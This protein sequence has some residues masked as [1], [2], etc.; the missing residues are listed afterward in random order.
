MNTRK[1][2]LILLLLFVVTA[3]G[4]APAPQPDPVP[5]E[6]VTAGDL[7]LPAGFAARI[8]VEGLDGPTQMIK[9]PDGRLWVAQLAGD[10]N[11]GI[12][13]ILAIDLVSGERRVVTSD[14]MKPTGIAVLGGYLWIATKRD[15]LRVP[16][17]DQGNAGPTEVVLQSLPY[18]GRSNGT[19]T[20]SP[21]G[22]LI[23][24]TSGARFGGTPVAGSAT[25][26]QLSPANPAEPVPLA[27]GLKNAYAH[28]FDTRGGL[29]VTEIADDPVNG[30]TPPDEL[31]LVVE[32]ADFGWPKCYAEHEP[33]L[34][35]GGTAVYCL[36]VRAAAMTFAPRSTPTS[37][38]SSPWEPDTLLVALWLQG[39]VARV[40][41]A[42]VGDNGTGVQETFIEGLRN[43]Q[44]ILVWN[45]DTILVSDHSAGKVY[46]VRTAPSGSGN[47][48]S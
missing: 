20:V 18:N 27:S 21:N 30:R 2:L 3:I 32:G 44:D 17:D 16:L 38:V 1:P 8:V 6:T 40:P 14:L 11:E 45:D 4:C 24:A 9:G 22:N 29:W 28:T 46:E 48:G 25:L 12:G 10:E 41:V 33:A 19:L 26:W 37:V 5:G 47:S 35:Y 31:N 43:P 7:V 39:I 15:L 34:N 42:Y 36:G 23:Y 13:E